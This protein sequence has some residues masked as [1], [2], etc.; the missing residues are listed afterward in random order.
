M[1]PTPR[2]ARRSA[3]AAAPLREPAATAPEETPRPD[4]ES[5]AYA[6]LDRGAMANL[7]RLTAGISPHAVVDAWSDWAMHLSRAPGRQLELMER[8][9]TNWLALARFALSRLNGGT[10]DKPFTPAPQDTRWSHDG[11]DRMPFALWQQG[12]LG[13]QDWWQAATADLPGLRRQN[14]RRTGFLMRQLLDTVSPSNFP[15]CNPEIIERTAADRGANLVEGA[16]HVVDDA[17]HVMAQEQRPVPAA[18]AIGEVLAATPGEVVYRN[19]LMELIQYAPTTG[20]VQAEPVLIVPAWIMKYYILD[21][22]PQNSL[23]R[24]LVDQGHTVFCISW[25]NPGAEQAELSLE[26]Y[27]TKASC[28]R[29]T[30]STPSCRVGRSTRTA[31]ASAARSL[32]SPPRPWRAIATTASPRSL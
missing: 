21:L 5:H 3:A 11:W 27:R 12:F 31:T 23:I 29:S 24:W 13:L 22:S 6:A 20:T 10:A 2:A 15:P 16:A 18:F 14:A 28:R 4:P 32:P 30:S 17:L 8:A 7:A 19:E 1:A 26:D 9:Q 25:R